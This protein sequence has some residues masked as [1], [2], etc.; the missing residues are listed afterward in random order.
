MTVNTTS[1][2]ELSIDRLV[3]LAIQKAGM[4]PAGAPR[5]GTQWE[6]YAVQARDFLEVEIDS[7]QAE[8]MLSRALELYDVT[9]VAGTATYALPATTLGVVGDAMYAAPSATNQTVVRSIDMA[10]Y[11]LISDKET[12]GTPSLYWPQALGTV[13]LYVWP[14]PDAAGTLTIPRHRLLADNDDG[15][16]TV[17]LERYWAKFLINAVAH[18]VAQAGGIDPNKLG[19][20]RSERE[21]FLQRA[22]SQ[23]ASA[24]PGQVVCTHTSAW[25]R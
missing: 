13:T 23:S 2:R 24:T 9:L 16:R 7:L 21:R 12:E 6:N 22:R 18:E 10:R 19:Y 15:T 3:Y 1:T 14:V 11:Q 5:S 8:G 20:I 25:N 17:D 4:L